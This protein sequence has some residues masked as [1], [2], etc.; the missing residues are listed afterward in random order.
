M[1]TK[2]MVNAAK[3]FLAENP[4]IKQDLKDALLF[5]THQSIM[6]MTEDD[7]KRYR[8]NVKLFELSLKYDW[9]SGYIQTGTQRIRCYIFGI[10]PN[11]IDEAK[12]IAMDA[13]QKMAEEVK[14]AGLTN[15]RLIGPDVESLRQGLK[16]EVI[17]EISGFN[18]NLRFGETEPNREI[19][20]NLLNRFRKNNR[21]TKQIYEELDKEVK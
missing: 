6:D 19:L 10:F 12:I 17:L 9:Y 3:R 16:A 7:A 5:I 13:A 18:P 14:A 4:N 8:R 15:V 1:V 20:D 21:T 11:Y 2:D